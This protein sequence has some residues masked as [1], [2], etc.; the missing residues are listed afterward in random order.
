MSG[1]GTLK[2][3]PHSQLVFPGR[4]EYVAEFQAGTVVL[5]SISGPNGL[6]LRTGNYVLVPSIREQSATTKIDRAPDGSFLISCLGGSAGVL[7]L[8][9]SS[10]EFLQVGQA[11]TVSPKGE[12]SVVLSPPQQAV[13][14]SPG[15][16]L[17]PKKGTQNFHSGWL[18]LGLAGAGA[19]LAAVNH[20]GGKQSVSPSSP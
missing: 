2:I 15:S 3:F 9:G 8:Q 18:L 19:A 17:M 11:V 20:G 7:T 1:K 10:G 6:T 12:L 14:G 5:N 16:T 13:S 4:Y